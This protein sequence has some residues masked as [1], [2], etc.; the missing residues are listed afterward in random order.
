VYRYFAMFGRKLK[1]NFFQL[2]EMRLRKVKRELKRFCNVISEIFDC[3][4]TDNN[5]EPI[6]NEVVHSFFL[7]KL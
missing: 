4:K 2:D 1:F 5:D 6:Q 7:N 3:F